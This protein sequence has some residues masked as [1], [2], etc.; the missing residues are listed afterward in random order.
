M[1]ELLEKFT[2]IPIY[3]I[4]IGVFVE[5][6]KRKKDTGKSKKP[7]DV[8]KLGI[9]NAELMYIHE[10]GSPINHVPSRPVLQMTIDYTNK[11]LLNNYLAK[12]IKSYAQSGFKIEAYEKELK[13][14]CLKMENYARDI[15][16]LNDGRLAP[17]TPKTI[18]G[19]KEIG[20]H[21]LFNTGQLARSIS[22]RLVKS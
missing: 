7:I 21:P 11:N 17:N 10:N 6:G 13:K 2:S 9:N 19:K 15:I 1:D 18:K 16:Y 22:C 20:N 8:V 12:A 5:G 14:L 3:Y 4:E